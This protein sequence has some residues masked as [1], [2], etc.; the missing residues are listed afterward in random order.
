MSSWLES[1]HVAQDSALIPPLRLGLQCHGHHLTAC[2]YHL[3]LM[4]RDGGGQSGE[5]VKA[6]GLLPTPP[7][8]SAAPGSYLID[9]GAIS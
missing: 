7:P 1:S 3:H 4:G 6:W 5:A 8:P 9:Q 2:P